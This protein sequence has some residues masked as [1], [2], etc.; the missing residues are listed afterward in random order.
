MIE[1]TE[2][3]FHRTVADHAMVAVVF[4]AGAP[5]GDALPLTPPHRAGPGAAPFLWGRVD[6]DAASGLARMFGVAGDLPVLLILREGIVLYREPIGTL[7][8]D[9]IAAVLERAAR[10]DMEA[11]RR[12]IERERLGRAALHERRVCPTARRLG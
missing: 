6:V 9:E 5:Q 2:D 8:S 4:A 10:L 7:G 12:E 1:L 11:V 3:N